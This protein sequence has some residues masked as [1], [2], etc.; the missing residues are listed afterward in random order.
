MKRGGP[1]H[2]KTKLLAKSLGL[3]RYAAV[4]ILECL[5]H[6]AAKHAR[7]G[8]IGKWS[9]AEIA[10]S[11]GFDGDP[12][13]LVAAL[14]TCRW[15]DEHPEHRL[16]IH[17]WHDH[18]DNGVKK[19][20]M[21][22]GESFVSGHI[23]TSLEKKVPPQP[24]PQ[25]QPQP[26]DIAAAPLA[27]TRRKPPVVAE[28]GWWGKPKGVQ[29]NA[30]ERLWRGITPKDYEH[31]AAAYPAVDVPVEIKRAGEWCVS[32]GAR[33]RRSDYRKFLNGWLSRTQDRGG[34]FGNRGGAGAK[35]GAAE[36]R[37]AR[38]ADEFAEPD[39]PLPTA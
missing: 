24:Q 27:P 20:V 5:F 9:N 39:L 3:P 19:T 1:E 37:E 32:N 23:Q 28:P 30:T 4:G 16:V 17:D 2:P 33:G 38:R 14:V 22:N 34:G 18:A 21:R 36:R 11:V 12:E 10:E 29:F 15:L 25:P 35:I 26:K 6:E 8:N 13:V 31:W 7:T